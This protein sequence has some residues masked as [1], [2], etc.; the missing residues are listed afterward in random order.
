MS[1]KIEVFGSGCAKCEALKKSAE[2]AA[3]SL[4]WSNVEIL[5]IKD[6]DEIVNRG[7]LST[8][9]LAV[10]GKILVSGRYL[11]PNKLEKLFNNL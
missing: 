9:A 3:E 6:M 10:D 8:P 11:P 5:Y 1:H 7:I 4:G 2:S